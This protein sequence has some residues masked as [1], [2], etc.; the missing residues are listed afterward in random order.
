[1]LAPEDIRR[2]AQKRYADYLRSLVDGTPFFPLPVRFGKPSPTEDF[3]KLRREINALT[4][5][6]LGCQIEWVEVNSRRWGKQRLP[7]RVTF[8]DENSY[9]RTLGKAKEAARFRDNLEL[10]RG[11]CATLIS[12]LRDRP[13]EV[14]EIAES[15]PGL[16]EVCCYLQFHPRPNLYARELPLT[17]DTKFVERHQS[18][19]TRLLK[20]ALP[21][22]AVVETGR[23]EEQF[24]LRFDEPQ[25]RV[26][27]LDESLRTQLGMAFNDFSIPIQQFQN[28]GWEK[29]RVLVSENKMT[30]LTLPKTPHA[31]AIWGAGNAAALLHSVSWLADCDLFYWGDI[32]VQGF[33]I[34]ARLREAF[35]KTRSMM[36][37][38]ATM[39]RFRDLCRPGVISKAQIK[40]QLIVGEEKAYEIADKF[41]LRLEQE[42]IP[43]QFAGDII[44]ANFPPNSS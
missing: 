37:D 2:R 31:I 33:E 36:M 43:N 6:N 32:D 44:G 5:A 30:F 26:R 10:T 15:W 28:L 4:K 18:V 13:L 14:V 16:I 11:R 23:F 35:P 1:M 27:L 8:A 9:L 24:G 39:N 19:L 29:L 25:V 41:N 42:R 40:Q 38:I 20:I 7:E 3:E 34:L 22:D 12:F 17:V 21:K